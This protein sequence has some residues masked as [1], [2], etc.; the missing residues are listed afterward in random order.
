MQKLRCPLLILLLAAMTPFAF[1]ELIDKDHADTINR[2]A[3]SDL[4]SLKDAM[5]R[6]D[7]AAEVS[8][9]INLANRMDR[10]ISGS[11][12]AILTKA[13]INDLNIAYKAVWDVGF[14]MLKTLSN[15][16]EKKKL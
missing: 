12:T 5:V 16:R 1:A 8:E 9:F 6:G 15:D 7:Q 4:Q 3:T 10:Q 13:Q 14:K 11:N 2:F